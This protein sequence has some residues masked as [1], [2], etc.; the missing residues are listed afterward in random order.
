MWRS[1]LARLHSSFPKDQSKI[2]GIMTWLI[3]EDFDDFVIRNRMRECRDRL[4]LTH[5]PELAI[6]RDLSDRHRM[7]GHEPVW[8]MH[9]AR[10]PHA[11]QEKYDRYVTH[12]NFTKR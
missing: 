8:A 1:I 12:S 6:I 2:D 9:K 3:Q 10:L 11:L 7:V 5:D 4:A